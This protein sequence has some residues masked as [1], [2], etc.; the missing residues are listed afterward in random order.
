MV[1][2]VKN[3]IEEAQKSGR[4]GKITLQIPGQNPRSPKKTE[5]LS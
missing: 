3:S 2:R 4:S 5:G 1:V